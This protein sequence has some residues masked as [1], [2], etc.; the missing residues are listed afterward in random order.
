MLLKK[1]DALF[2][3]L[4]AVRISDNKDTTLVKTPPPLPAPAAMVDG[5]AQL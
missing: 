5:L 2:F 1:T 4:F 3:I